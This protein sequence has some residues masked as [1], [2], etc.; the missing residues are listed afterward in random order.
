MKSKSLFWVVG[1]LLFLSAC[2]PIQFVNAF[3]SKA[4][5]LESDIAYGDL[6]LQ[7]LDVYTRPDKSAN[8]VVIF[9]HGGYWDSDDKSIYPFLA[10]SLTEGGFI[11]VVPNYRLVPSITFPSYVEDLALAVKWTFQNIQSYGGNPETIYLMGHSAGA[12]IASLV[13]FD[14]RYLE[15]LGIKAS[16]LKGFIGIAGPYDFLPLA[17]DDIRSMAA[18]GPQENWEQTQPINFVDGTEPPAFLAYTPSDK[19]VNPKNTLHFAERIREKGGR[20]TEKPY[21]GVDHLTILGALGRG[22][23]ILNQHILEDVLAFLQE[24]VK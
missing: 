22:G 13:A 15:V 14:E 2:T 10:D 23:R 24:N 8:G 17:P 12:H 19:T 3:A 7:T 11:T 5:H 16:N 1:F 4:L 21:E 9:V 6:E 20:I 18:L